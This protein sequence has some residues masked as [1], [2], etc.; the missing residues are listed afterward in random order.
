MIKVIS[1]FRTVLVCLIYPFFS[2]VCSA[3]VILTNITLGSRQIDD[4]FIR[5]WSRN[6]CRMF[7]VKVEVKGLE[8][9]PK[10]G[11]LYLFNH[12]SWFDI[13]SM[14][15]YLPSFRFGAKIE[16]FQIP[17]FGP[18]MARAGVLPIN[19]SQR[20][21]VFKVY[22]QS[23]E[24][25]LRGEKFALSPEGTRQELEVLAPFKAGPFIFAI[26]AQAPIVPVIIKNA[27]AVMPKGAWLPNWD[28]W[29]RTISIEVLPAISTESETLETRQQLQ[30]KLHAVMEPYFTRQV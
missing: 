7:G 22:E 27:S 19:R 6:T 30:A 29:S 9:V 15:G 12:T 18:A 2:A 8:N 26:S 10:G 24:R 5:F 25:I 4:V 13:F 23:R 28:V 16:L 21:E 1:L 20:E 3:L 11:C 14:T 17:I